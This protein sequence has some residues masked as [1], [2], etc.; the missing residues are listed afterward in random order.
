MF[1]CKLGIKHFS[2][3]IQSELEGIHIELGIKSD[4]KQGSKKIS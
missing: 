3:R 2:K 1:Y 4:S